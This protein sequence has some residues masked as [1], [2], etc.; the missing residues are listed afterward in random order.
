MGILPD[1]VNVS[2]KAEGAQG[3]A[4]AL[5]DYLNAKVGGGIYLIRWLCNSDRLQMRIKGMSNAEITCR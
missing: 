1:I 5:K 4:Q 2:D 3:V